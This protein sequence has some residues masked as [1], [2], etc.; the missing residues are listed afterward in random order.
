M[1]D[2]GQP[3]P[4]RHPDDRQPGKY[5]KTPDDEACGADAQKAVPESDP[6]SDP[7]QAEAGS[8]HDQRGA[9]S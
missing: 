1:P 9:A 5:Q 7:E 4:S 8:D 2:G 3:L 6:G